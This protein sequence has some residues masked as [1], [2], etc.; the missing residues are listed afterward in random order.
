M[1]QS[2]RI[3]FMA[4]EDLLAHY[5][6]GEYWQVAHDDWECLSDESEWERQVRHYGEFNDEDEGEEVVDENGTP[7]DFW[8]DW[9]EV[10][11][12][13]H[14]DPN[15]DL[16]FDRKP[17]GEEQGEHHHYFMEEN[18]NPSPNPKYV[19]AA[20]RESKDHAW[21]T[22]RGYHRATDTFFKLLYTLPNLESLHL[23]N[24]LVIP[25]LS[26]PPRRLVQVLAGLESFS[27]TPSEEL[28]SQ[29]FQVFLD[30]VEELRKGSVAVV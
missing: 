16:P 12:D 1:V 25:D 21:S 20:L 19:L 4:K 15:G 9:V 17:D 24:F 23:T 3:N 8:D 30:Q 26:S 18:L 2:V 28:D 29:D 7:L 14:T 6:E 13:T 27:A 5:E 11:L 22:P 10:A